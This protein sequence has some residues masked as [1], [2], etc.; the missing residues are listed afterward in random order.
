MAP[1]P[2][3]RDSVSAH[4]SSELVRA[5][6]LA[7]GHLND[8][9]ALL[10]EG[11]VQDVRQFARV[12]CPCVVRPKRTYEPFKVGI[13]ELAGNDPASIKLALH[14]HDVSVLPIVE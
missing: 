9:G 3:R 11:A 13:Q 4:R 6:H 10:G 2:E 5:R 12:R 14:L 1:M 8:G 7:D